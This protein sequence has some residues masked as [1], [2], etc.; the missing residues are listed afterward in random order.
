MKTKYKYTIILLLILTLTSCSESTF[1]TTEK[2][3]EH[4][5]KSIQK[6]NY[7]DMMDCFYSENNIYDLSNYNFEN[8]KLSK[9]TLLHYINSNNANMTYEIVYSDNNSVQV[10][11]SYL[12]ATDI[13]NKT[14]DAY[15]NDVVTKIET[16]VTFEDHESIGIFQNYFEQISTTYQPTN[17]TKTITFSYVQTSDGNY[18][19]DTF[20]DEFFDIISSNIFKAYNEY[21]LAI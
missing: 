13:I 21:A 2:N 3:A 17:A 7:K 10:E 4:L 12:D 6:N 15:L 16:G 19:I 14:L 20:D 9:G 5:C 11:F 8:F 1:S 18:L